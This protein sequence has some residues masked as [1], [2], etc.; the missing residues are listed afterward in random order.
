METDEPEIY[1]KIQ[2]VWMLVTRRE[3][4]KKKKEEKRESL[5]RRGGFDAT[6][7][8]FRRV[9]IRRDVPPRQNASEIGL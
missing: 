1:S 5:R 7:N 4:K 9:G 3:G 8:L 2:N 6:G